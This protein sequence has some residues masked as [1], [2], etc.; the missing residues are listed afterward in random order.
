MKRPLALV[1]TLL[2]CFVARAEMLDTPPRAIE[3]AQP[4][5]PDLDRKERRGGMVTI[6]IRVDERSVA[7][8]ERI[9]GSLHSLTVAVR[10]AAKTWRFEAARRQGRTPIAEVI[11]I[12]VI[13]DPEKGVEIRGP[14]MRA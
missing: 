6:L 4:A 7:T 14:L 10:A 3:M 9:M 13:F 5:Y 12:V 1:L 11:E 8:V 2:L